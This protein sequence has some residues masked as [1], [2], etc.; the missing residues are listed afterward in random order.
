MVRSINERL[1]TRGRER[2]SN[3]MVVVNDLQPYGAQRVAVEVAKSLVGLS[4]RLTLV[5]L[6][7]RGPSDIAIPEG[8]SRLSLNRSRS[9]AAGYAQMVIGLARVFRSHRPSAVISNMLFS[10]ICVL[11]A[12]KL[13][14]GRSAP[15]ICVEHN[16]PGNVS[17][18]K[19]PTAIRRLA[20]VLYPSAASIVGVSEAVALASRVEYGLGLDKTCTIYNPVDV[21]E[22]QQNGQG[23]PPHRWLEKDSAG[24]VVV[25]AA[26]FR[27]AKGQDVLVNALVEAPAVR[28]I[29]VGDGATKSEIERLAERL[30]VAERIDFVGFRADVHRYMRHASALVVPSRWEGF[31]LVA[32]EAACL[33][34]PVIGTEVEGLSE[35]VPRFVPGILVPPENARAL[36]TALRNFRVEVPAQNADLSVFSPRQVASRYAELIASL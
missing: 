34:T 36:A 18:E 24:P 21:T 32:V 35:L 22:V 2:L 26:G 1:A 20:K 7:K 3:P 16:V 27:H 8:I 4:Q 17:I 29:F 15:A 19:S 12:Q 28:A 10:N 9:G 5:T 25:C 30:G 6:E 13:A 11:A 31:G 14:I 23:S 33:G